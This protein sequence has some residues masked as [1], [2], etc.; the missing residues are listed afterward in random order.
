MAYIAA[1]PWLLS[2]VVIND[3]GGSGGGIGASFAAAHAVVAEIEENRSKAIFHDA[4]VAVL[5]KVE[6]IV[7]AKRLHRRCLSA[8]P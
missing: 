8:L 6:G 2:A 3:Y 5:S 1:M 4:N 7:Q